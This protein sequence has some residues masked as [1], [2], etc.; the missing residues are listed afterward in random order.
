MPPLP[1]LTIASWSPASS[2][3]RRRDLLE[4]AVELSLQQHA[5][6]LGGKLRERQDQ[7]DADDERNE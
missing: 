5:R 2:I 6:D 4:A 3:V 1:A 7:A